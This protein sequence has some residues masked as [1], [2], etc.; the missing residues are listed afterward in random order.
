M[1][2]ACFDVHLCSYDVNK[3]TNVDEA[4]LQ[5]DV[6]LV[7]VMSQNVLG[8]NE[9]LGRALVPIQPAIG[10]KDMLE[11]RLLPQG[12]F[13]PHCTHVVSSHV[14]VL[15]GVHMCGFTCAYRAISATL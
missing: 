4:S 12:T 10:L 5:S 13:Q 14:Q 3:I 7:E 2:V 11:L 8:S 15:V 1:R 9:F 6:L